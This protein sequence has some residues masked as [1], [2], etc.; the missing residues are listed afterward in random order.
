MRDGQLLCGGL[1]VLTRA[2][3]GREGDAGSGRSQLVPRRWHAS[4]ACSQVAPW[5]AVIVPEEVMVPLSVAVQHAGRPRRDRLCTRSRTSCSVTRR[6]PQCCALRI[7]A[8]LCLPY[9]VPEDVRIPLGVAGWRG[10]LR[11]QSFTGRYD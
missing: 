9:T 4:Q 7:P 2:C 3:W 8:S 6:L 10:Q 11:P 5:H 1:L